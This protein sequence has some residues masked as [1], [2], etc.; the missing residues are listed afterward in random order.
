MLERIEYALKV[1]AIAP[2][3]AGRIIAAD[4]RLIY[5]LRRGRRPSL[6]MRIR[7]ENWLRRLES[8]SGAC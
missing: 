3:T 7:L 5:D 8:Q 4:P 6:P 1:H 2:S